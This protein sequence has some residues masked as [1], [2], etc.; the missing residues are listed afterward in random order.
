MKNILLTGA[1]GFVGRTLINFLEKEEC[2]I[3]LLT[4]KENSN[5]HLEHTCICHNDYNFTKDIF[6]EAGI[7][8]IDIVIHLGA[9]TPKGHKEMNNVDGNLSTIVNTKALLKNLPNYPDKFIYCSTVSV[10]GGR[11]SEISEMSI[12]QPDTLYGISKLFCE[13]M[14]TE[15]GI[16]NGVLVGI[17]RFGSLYGEK[18]NLN[19]LI[20][21]MIKKTINGE[22]I[23]IFSDGSEKRSYLYV[24]DCCR[25]L[26]KYTLHMDVT[27]T[28]NFVSSKTY[29]INDILSYIASVEKK[30][31]MIEYL[32]HRNGE[33]DESYN[34][35]RLQTIL[36]LEETDI[37]VGIG[38]EY[39]YWETIMK[40]NN[41]D[42]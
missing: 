3:I 33:D 5:E 25:Y 14:I 11:S 23:T 40:G 22:K 39:K 31:L 36:G 34:V 4:S 29:S 27:E 37:R 16:E 15:W 42:N 17:V 30:E 28:I 8:K 13:K 35:E 1:S 18:E 41:Y 21:F 32:N 12:P 24:E 2:N 7:N 20:P 9:F 6:F 19:N 26:C 10:Y 38:R